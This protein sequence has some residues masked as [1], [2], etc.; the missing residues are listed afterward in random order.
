VNRDGTIKLRRC[1]QREIGRIIDE[2]TVVERRT[3]RKR[4]RSV[5][6]EERMRE[7]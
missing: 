3:R 6:R 4:A 5:Q 1:G 2:E 7:V